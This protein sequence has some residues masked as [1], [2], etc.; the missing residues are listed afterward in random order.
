MNYWLCSQWPTYLK[1]AVFLCR[2]FPILKKVCLL[3]PYSLQMK[4]EHHL[5]MG[6]FP[7]AELALSAWQVC[8]VCHQLVICQGGL[9]RS[10]L[11]GRMANKHLWRVFPR[12]RL[13][14]GEEL[15][16]ML[17]KPTYPLQRFQSLASRIN[18]FGINRRGLGAP[19][20]LPGGKGVTRHKNKKC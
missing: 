5:Q 16:R 3:P 7:V 13:A 9:L 20:P 14:M 4:R 17:P 11:D 10:G 15:Q 8:Q 12:I 1:D 2:V 19:H 18:G 6:D